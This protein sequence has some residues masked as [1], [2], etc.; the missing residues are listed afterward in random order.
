MNPFRSSVALAASTF[1]LSGCFSYVPAD[2]GAV[3]TGKDVRVQVSRIALAR[4]PEDVADDGPVYDGTLVAAEGDGVTLE[5]PY[6]ERP[7]VFAQAPQGGR[8]L[9]LARADVV[10]FE[11]KQFD[12]GNTALLVGGAVGVTLL[13]LKAFVFKDSGSQP[14]GPP[15]P[16]L[17]RVPVLSLPF[18]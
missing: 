16:N 10:Q 8:E 3:P 12:A 4:L 14:G 5:I 7:S 6:R 11:R 17:V 15:D 13:A 18:H 1:L 9:H 2:F